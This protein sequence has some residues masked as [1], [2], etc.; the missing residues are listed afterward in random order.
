ML[1]WSLSQNNCKKVLT[2][3][4]ITS[5]EFKK[6]LTGEDSILTD[7]IPQ[8]AFIGRSNVGKSSVINTLV[9]MRDLAH[10]SQ[11]PGKTR[12]VNFF[13]INKSFYLVDLPGYGYAEGSWAKRDE[14]IALI[15]WYLQHPDTDL[16][17]VVLIIDAK[18]GL[19]DNDR[20]MLEL[21]EV[22]RRPVVVLA[23]KIDK[24]KPQELKKQLAHIEAEIGTHKLIP[25]S[26]EKKLGIGAL[27][28]EMLKK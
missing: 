18:V 24:V 9:G 25:Y 15:H 7:G 22:E 11:R 19:T 2:G 27:T 20:S 12:E 1:L 4:K 6:G 3:M 26:A 8:V 23:N 16:Q 5:A 21:L 28:D 17:K 13:L 10:S 14:I